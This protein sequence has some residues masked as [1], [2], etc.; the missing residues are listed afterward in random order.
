MIGTEH[1]YSSSV[2]NK[3]VALLG[4]MPPPL[5]GVSV[6]MQRVTDL[7]I[8]QHNSVSFFSTEHWLRKFFPLYACK[9]IGWLLYKRPN[10]VYYHSTYLSYSLSELVLLLCMRFFLRYE[11]T[12]I[13]HD[14]RHLSKKTARQKR[15]YAWIIQKIHRVVCIGISTYQSYQDNGIALTNYT[16]ESAFIPPALHRAS[17]IKATYPSSLHTFMQEHTPLFLLSAAHLMLIDGKDIYGIDATSAMLSELKKEYPDAGLIIGLS[18]I[19]N[20]RY[21]AQLQA[22]IKQYDVAEQIFFLHGN[23]ELWPLFEQ[24]DIFLRPTLSDGDS[25]SVREALYFNKPVVASDVVARPHDVSLYNV[26]DADAYAQT[27]SLV[28]QDYIYGTQRK[29]NNLHQ[30]SAL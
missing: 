25:I 29:C 1:A 18:T 5:G 26:Y 10:S 14:C 9:L 30:K 21:F 24:I 4:I 13:D 15:I 27:V 16:I 28:L 23:K 7:F 6:H 22:R 3:K 8:S 11:I 19:G 2:E 12:I 20:H 17:A